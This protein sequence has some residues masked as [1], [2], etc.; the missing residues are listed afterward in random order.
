MAGCIWWSKTTYL[1]GKQR[2]GDEGARDET[3]PKDMS[4]APTSSNQALVS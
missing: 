2:L 3:H 4:S 1:I